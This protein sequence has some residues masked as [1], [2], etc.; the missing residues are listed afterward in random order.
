MHKF[1]QLGVWTLAEEYI[2]DTWTPFDE[3]NDD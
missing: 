2:V 1:V 3:Q